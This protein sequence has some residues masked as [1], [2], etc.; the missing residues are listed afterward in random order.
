MPI[1]VMAVIFS[2]FLLFFVLLYRTKPAGFL[3]LLLIPALIAISARAQQVDFRQLTEERAKHVSQLIENHHDRVGRYPENLRE[4]TP[5]YA[6][7]LPGPVIIYGEDWCYDG[8]VDYF[9][10]GYIYRE[11]WSSPNLIGQIYKSKGEIPD[12]HPMCEEEAAALMKRYPNS[13]WTFGE[14]ERGGVKNGLDKE[15]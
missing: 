3:Y 5:W 4:L 12:L 9:R 10:L 8:S 6:F 2:S 11:H 15:A 7:P 14:E 13:F 1:P